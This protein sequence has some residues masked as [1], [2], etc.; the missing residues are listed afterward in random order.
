MPPKR[1]ARGAST[2][3]KSVSKSKANNAKRLIPISDTPRPEATAAMKKGAW[4]EVDAKA[5]EEIAR[6]RPPANLVKR[7]RR[8]AD[9]LDKEF[10]KAEC[11]LHYTTALQLLV[12]TILS[13]QCTDARVNIVTPALFK[14][15]PTALDFAQ[16]PPGELEEDI[17]TTGFFNNKAK[18]IRACCRQLVENHGGKVP[19]DMETLSSL[20]GVGRKTAAV[21]RANV[22]HLPGITVDTHVQRVSGRLRLTDDTDPQRIEFDIGSLLPPERWSQFSHATI[23]HGRKT[24]SARR[25]DCAA[26]PLQAVC[27][28]AG[29]FDD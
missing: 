24:C 26:C 1:K 8:V 21:V 17:R 19:R 4:R 10:P 6:R 16:S 23:L 29:T 13:A 14:K 3:K 18:S 15:F 28:S 22:F 12:A 5:R 2:G 25:P 27:P 11:A 20:P 9:I 7:A